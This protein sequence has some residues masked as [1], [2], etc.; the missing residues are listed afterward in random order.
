MS[1][2]QSVRQVSPRPSS[3]RISVTFDIGDY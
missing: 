1:V 3:G 2:R